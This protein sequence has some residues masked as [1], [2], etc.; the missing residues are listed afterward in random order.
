[1]AR[2]TTIVGIKRNGI[3]N[4]TIEFRGAG[5]KGELEI[6]GGLAEFRDWLQNSNRED[7]SFLISLAL[8]S[9]V[10]KNPA[11]TDFSALVGKT[12]TLDFGAPT[13]TGIVTII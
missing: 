13:L 6:P 3:K 4:T 12:V 5:A 11:A 7:V 1:M 9:W 2:S 10:V 8:R